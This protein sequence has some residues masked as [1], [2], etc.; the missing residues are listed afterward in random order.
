MTHI[1]LMVVGGRGQRGGSGGRR[2]RGDD[3][4]TRM[5]QGG[6]K[7][8]QHGCVGYWGELMVT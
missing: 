2:S 1:A 6:G 3:R 8:S 4:L 7:I 5:L